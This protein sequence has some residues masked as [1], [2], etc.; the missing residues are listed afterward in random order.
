[1]ASKNLGPVAGLYIGTSAPDNTT[2]IWYDE[3][4]AI[5]CHKVYN[6]ELGQWVIL[7]DS[8]ISSITYSV[9]ENIAQTQGLT[10]G[11]WFKITDKNNVLALAITT[12]KVQYTDIMSNVV[13]DDLGHNVSY[14]VS[15][16]NLLID[17]ITGVW[18]AVNNKL[19]FSFAETS[20]GFT[21]D[22]YLFG[23]QRVNS[24]WSL[25]K[26]KITK[27]LSTDSGNSLSWSNG[28]FLNFYNKLSSY[29]DVAG[30]IVS[31]NAYDVDKYN[32]NQ[33]ID[34]V[35]NSISQVITATQSIVATATSDA[36]IYSKRLPVAPTDAT[37]VPIAQYD[38]L[39]TIVLKLYR[40]VNKLMYATGINISSNYSEA[41]TYQIVNNNDTVESAIGKL[42]YTAR[43]LKDESDKQS[44]G[45][46]IK[47][48]YVPQERTVVPGTTDLT[49]FLEN[50]QYQINTLKQITQ[51]RM[52]IGG[53][54]SYAKNV[55]YDSMF[56]SSGAGI[57]WIPCVWIMSSPN[58]SD[59]DTEKAKW[60]NVYNI[61][62]EFETVVN[63]GQTY[64][65]IS[66][67]SGI[68]IPNLSGMALMGTA[69]FDDG[70]SDVAVQGT[71]IGTNKKTLQVSN[72]PT[73][74]HVINE[75]GAHT[76]SVGYVSGSNDG[77]GT[78]HGLLGDTGDTTWGTGSAG[79][80]SHTCQESGSGT[81]FDNRPYSYIVNYLIRVM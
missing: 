35:A 57:G 12:T 50:V 42:A 64:L 36:N 69:M 52:P 15:S 77:S 26:F 41:T 74:S 7:D 47:S 33:S 54:V 53:I 8:V 1:M 65:R 67:C 51:V 6:E 55:D 28:L 48:T 32:T 21:D 43:Y 39:Q 45:V 72:M 38:T 61:N 80:H 19:V 68:A 56:G 20:P 9:L 73:H 4:P 11:Q 2:L 24:V 76:H 62:I 59:I 27:L 79:A 66:R 75:A 34:N 16:S 5:K 81:A 30:G 46:I 22:Y 58:Y 23:K 17:D 10:V 60:Q 71:V 13:V 18:D 49:K 40:W 44:D 63:N 37:P 31:K 78:Y 14:I 25:M 29:F 3:T 70:N